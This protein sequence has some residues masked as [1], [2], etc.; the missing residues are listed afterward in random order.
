[1][2]LESSSKVR[3][4]YWSNHWTFGLIVRFAN[5]VN[6][7]MLSRRRRDD[8]AIDAQVHPLKAP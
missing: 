3:F 6:I 2:L 1:M 5:R 7:D 8:P 4:A